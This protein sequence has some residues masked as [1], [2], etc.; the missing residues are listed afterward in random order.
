[1][2]GFLSRVTPTQ[3]FIFVVIVSVALGM[4]SQACDDDPENRPELIKI[5][6]DVTKKVVIQVIDSKYTSFALGIAL[7][8]YAA[9]YL[10]Q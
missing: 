6:C 8:V 5:P 7:L 10:S 1:M 2:L 9:V 4:L 3:L